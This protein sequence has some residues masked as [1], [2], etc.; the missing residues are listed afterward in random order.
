M[1]GRVVDENGDPIEDAT[2]S[3][4]TMTIVGGRRPCFWAARDRCSDDFGR[5][6]PFSVDPGEMRA[7]RSHCGVPARIACPATRRRTF[8]ERRS[9]ADAQVVAVKTGDE[10]FL[11]WIGDWCRG[12]PQG[13]PARSW[14]RPVS[15]SEGEMLLDPA[16]GPVRWRRRRFASGRTRTATFE[17]VNI[18]PGDYVSAGVGTR[19]TTVI[20]FATRFLVVGE[21]RHRR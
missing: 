1:T 11:D 15:H 16:D 19:P 3:I 13:F 5:F 14:T 10:L 4:Y 2:V 9:L 20:E 17:F 21:R 18:A 12:V 7:R 8:Q 6:R